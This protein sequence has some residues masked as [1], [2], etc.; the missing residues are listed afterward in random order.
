MKPS[1]TANDNPIDLTRQVWQPRL[2]SDLNH[3]AARQIAENVTG[4]FTLLAK[5]SRAE[6]PSSANDIGKP[7]ASGGEE[8]CHER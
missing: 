4:F 5:W 8:A 6:M 1:R 2:G 3:E 7:T